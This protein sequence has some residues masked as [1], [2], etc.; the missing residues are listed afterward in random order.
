MTENLFYLTTTTDTQYIIYCILLLEIH[1]S[2]RKRERQ[3][4]AERKDFSSSS[5]WFHAIY[6]NIFL[7]FLGENFQQLLP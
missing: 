1:S 6:I 5:R 4:Q 7:D 3:G 2:I